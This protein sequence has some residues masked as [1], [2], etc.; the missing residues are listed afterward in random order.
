M[1]SAA[2]CAELSAFSVVKQSRVSAK[3]GPF[4]V[5]REDLCQSI[6]HQRGD[7]MIGDI[8][9][10][11]AGLVLL[12]HWLRGG[13]ARFAAAVARFDVVIGVVAVVIG[14]LELLSVQGILLILAGLI[15]AVSALRSGPSIGGALAQMGNSLE[16]FRLITGVLVLL[17]GI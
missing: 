5:L 9:A 14:V 10:I 15:L 13:A 1:N 11:L 6:N 2:Y 3:P 12:A 17:V 8:I 7:K 4:R 16:Q